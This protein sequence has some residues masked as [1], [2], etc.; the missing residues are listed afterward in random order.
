M[1]HGE[2]PGG[3][4]AHSHD[5]VQRMYIVLHPE[6]AAPS[7]RSKRQIPARRD[8][9]SSSRKTLTTAA[10]RSTSPSSSPT[11][12]ATNVVVDQHSKVSS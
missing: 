4:E 7:R 6:A 10:N 3:D 12:F 8:T 9:S 5:D 2:E 1:A 11:L